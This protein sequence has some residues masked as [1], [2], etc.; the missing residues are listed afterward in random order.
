MQI[1]HIEHCVVY[2]SA[3]HP[4]N[5]VR[6]TSRWR[7]RRHQQPPSVL[8]VVFE[9]ALVL[10][11]SFVSI[12][13]SHKI[14]SGRSNFKWSSCRCT[15]LAPVS[16][17]ASFALIFPNWI[18]FTILY[19]SRIGSLC[20][21]SAVELSFRTRHFTL[22]RFFSSFF[23]YF[24]FRDARMRF[25]RYDFGMVARACATRWAAFY[26]VQRTIALDLQCRPHE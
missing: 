4:V 8:C 16:H 2:R 23:D 20:G 13:N 26:W 3:S 15:R 14:F 17:W 9:S 25:F 22:H 11:A 10:P 7:R 12:L 1:C 21:A 24:F 6:Y 19:G 18:M 5:C